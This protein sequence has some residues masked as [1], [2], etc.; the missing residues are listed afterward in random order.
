MNLE[1]HY[2][3]FAKQLLQYFVAHSQ[4]FYDE[5]HA[6]YN[7]HGLMHL[8]EDMR[9]VR[10]LNGISPFLLKMTCKF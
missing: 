7:V 4:R 8:S 10:S 1:N 6:V 3:N 5:T 2:A 9:F